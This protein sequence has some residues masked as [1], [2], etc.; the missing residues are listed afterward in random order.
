MDS[1][2]ADIVDAYLDAIGRR[3]YARARA[4][5]ADSGFEY[6]SPLQDFTS[7][8]RLMDYF[9]LALPIMQR[10]VVRRIFADG[11]ECCHMLLVTAQI[12]EKHATAAALWSK[13]ADGRIVRMEAIFDAHEYKKLLL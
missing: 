4:L 10:I 8:D 9:E 13:V 2:A 5:L 3:D 7:A 12:S 11:D 1:H 6:R